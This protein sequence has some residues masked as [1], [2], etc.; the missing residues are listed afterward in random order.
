MT[1]EG[2]QTEPKLAWWKNPGSYVMIVGALLALFVIWLDWNIPKE[3]FMGWAI[4]YLSPW[5]GLVLLGG[6]IYLVVRWAF[7]LRIA[8]TTNG[9]NRQV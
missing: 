2:T 1:I 9:T 8:V 4:E 7:R 6:A 3:S 5:I